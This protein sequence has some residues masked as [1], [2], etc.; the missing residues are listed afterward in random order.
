MF[1]I[2]LLRFL[3]ALYLLAAVLYTS[4]Y[5]LL[6]PLHSC[7]SLL[8][9]HRVPNLREWST[10]S[11]NSLL[12][13]R[14]SAPNF[15]QLSDPEVLLEQSSHWQDDI[16]WRSSEF[17]RQNGLGHDK[18]IRMSQSLFLSKAFANSMRPSKIVPFFYR[19]TGIFDKDDITIT[20]LVTS[21][22]FHVL[23]RLVNNYSGPISATVHVKNTTNHVHE[24]LDALHA[25]YLSSPKMASN[26]D[27]HL[28]I[29]SA[30]REAS[31]RQH[32]NSFLEL[33]IVNS[34]LGEILPV[35]SPAQNL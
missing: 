31:L 12:P 9:D 5:F 22:R 28:V 2:R 21:N 26:V 24:L 30:F 23:A 10:S 14:S 11:F 3:L 25:L 8:L 6:S 15:D 33:L 27:V 1:I 4:N 34:T 32:A 18:P 13:R 17:A 19:A 7:L 20:T 16:Y 35:S 29:D